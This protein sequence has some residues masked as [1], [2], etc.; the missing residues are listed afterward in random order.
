MVAQ[1]VYTRKFGPKQYFLSL[2]SQQI[3]S[4]SRFSV[5]SILP[6][7]RRMIT[8]LKSW[9]LI[10][11]RKRFKICLAK[12]NHFLIQFFPR[13]YL[14]SGVLPLSSLKHG[15]TVKKIIAGNLNSIE[16]LRYTDKIMKYHRFSALDC[17][18]RF[19]PSGATTS[20]SFS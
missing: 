3:F 9:L 1:R 17:V 20:P 6:W 8:S 11:D 4:F 5:D 18:V 19:D 13:I 12:D 15:L 2:K 10:A 14:H 16:L 7:S